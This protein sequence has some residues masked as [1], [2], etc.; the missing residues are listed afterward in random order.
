[1][2]TN[3]EILDV[4]KYGKNPVQLVRNDKEVVWMNEAG[5]GSINLALFNLSDEE[6]TIHFSLC[7]IGF[8]KA[9]LRDLWNK[10]DCGIV[11]GNIVVEIPPHG[12]ALYRL[13][14]S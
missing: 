12:A 6:H 14:G 4:Q 1:L 5:E 11:E 2:L 10:Q 7:N 13:T 3:P 9:S 8:Q